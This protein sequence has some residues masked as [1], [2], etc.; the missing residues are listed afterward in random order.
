MGGAMPLGHQDE[1]G[2]QPLPKGITPDDAARYTKELIDSLRKIAIGQNHHQLARLLEAAGIEAES[3]A[4]HKPP[5][6]KSA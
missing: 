1:A 2:Q 6:R 4:A 3:L 5:E